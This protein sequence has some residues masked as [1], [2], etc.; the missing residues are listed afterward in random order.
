[1]IGYCILLGL[2][3]RRPRCIARTTGIEGKD[4]V[5]LNGDGPEVDWK[6][7]K[8]RYDDL[9]GRVPGAVR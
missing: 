1:M 7:W 5:R 3:I 4:D 2:Q 8:V 9:G 6:W